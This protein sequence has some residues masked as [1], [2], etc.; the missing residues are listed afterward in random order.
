MRPE[1]TRVYRNHHLDSTYWDQIKLRNDDIIISTSLKTGTTWT[2]RIVSLLVSAPARCR[3]SRPAVAVDR[4]A[5]LG[6]AEACRTGRE[7]QT[8]RRF[9]KSHMPL[10]AIPYGPTNQVHLRRP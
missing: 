1:R 2:Q 9:F 4:L 3:E 7:A 5:L 10:D 6:T 8:H